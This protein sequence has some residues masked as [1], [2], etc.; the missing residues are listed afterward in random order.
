MISNEGQTVQKV[1]IPTS[2]V[3]QPKSVEVKQEMIKNEETAKT[4]TKPITSNTP[5]SGEWKD[6]IKHLKDSGKMS[7]YATLVSTSAVISNEAVIINFAQPFGKIV[8][9]KPENLAALKEAILAITGKE[10]PIKCVV[11]G[12][13]DKPENNG[14]EKNLINSGIDV[15]IV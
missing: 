5:V 12:Q 3:V 13:N 4:E 11:N 15:N 2:S 1:V 8:V 7:L 14:I 6:V 10:L 9:E